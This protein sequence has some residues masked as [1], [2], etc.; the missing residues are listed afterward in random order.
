MSIDPSTTGAIRDQFERY[1]VPNY[2]RFPVELDRRSG[3]VQ[4]VGI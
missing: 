2:G 3:T 4:V 1:V